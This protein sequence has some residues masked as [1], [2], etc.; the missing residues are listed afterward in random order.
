MELS[1]RTFL[2]TSSLAASSLV[3]PRFSIAQSGPSANSKLN[4][5]MIGTGNIAFRAFDGTRGENIVAM[6]DVDSSAFGRYTSRFPEISGARKFADFRVMLDEMEDQIDAVC[7]S[8]PDHSHF[9]A[10][11][12]AMQRGKHVCVQKPLTHNIWQARTL[13]KAMHRY[14]LVTNMDNQGH[15][16]DGIRTMREWY[17]SGALGDVSEVH[18]GQPG[19]NWG[20]GAFG[21]PNLPIGGDPV[22]ESL[23]WDLWIGPVQPRAYDKIYHPLKWRGFYD[24]GTGMLGDWFCHIGDGPVW[25]LDLYEPTV[26]EC[27]ERGPVHTDGMIPDYSV[28]RYDFPARGRH[29][30][31]SMYWYDGSRNGGS[32][33]KVPSDWDLGNAPNIGS[34]WFG[35]KN[36]AYLDERSNNPR[37]ST[38][39]AM[40]DFNRGKDIAQVYER[41]KFNNPFAEWVAAIKGEISSCGSNFDYSARLTETALLGTLAQRFGGRIEW[42][43]DKGITNRPELNQYVKEP[44]REGWNYGED[45]WRA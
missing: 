43:V 30:P 39:Q 10:A 19:P 17:E 5:A 22:P 24:F 4:I 2:K 3:L 31:C 40:M 9:P 14:D 44:A 20:G 6:A 7:I 1:R 34:Y 36:N 15:T 28:I 42:D 12:E 23:D 21:K 37:L 25:I 13:R 11:M 33:M 38:R 32:T 45:L 26:I 27:V 41:V 29:A 8:V 16:Y 18:L 35:S